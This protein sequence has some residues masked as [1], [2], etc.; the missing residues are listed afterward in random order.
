MVTL[1]EIAKA[2]KDNTLIM[3]QLLKLPFMKGLLAIKAGVQ[4]NKTVL[5]LMTQMRNITTAAMF[6]TANGHIGKGASVADNF[7]ILFDDFVGKNKDP[8]KLKETL[9][10][11]LENG[12]LDSSTIAQELEQLI[13]EL[14]GPSSVGGK[15]IAQGKTSDQIIEQLFTRKGALGKVVNKAIESY[16]LGDNLWKLF[17][18]NYT[19]SQLK[20]ALKNL[21]DVK[22]YFREIEG[23]EFRPLKADGTKKT[24]DDALKEIAGIQ[25]R[26]VYPNYS[27]IP[28]FVQNVR[29]FPVLGNFVAFISEMWRNSFQ[30]ARRGIREMKST[31][32]YLRQIGARRLLGYTTTVGIA[33]PVAMESAQ[34]MTGITEEMYDAYKNRFAPEYEKTS[35]MMPVTKQQ[36]DRSWKASNLS[37]LVPYADV[38]APF[39]AAFQTVQEGRNTDQ[40]TA[41]LYADA[42][43]QF[44]MRGLEPFLAPSI[45]FETSQ[46]LIPNENLQFRTKQGGLIADMKN[47]P[48]WFSKVL[49]HTYK[50][51][52]PT[53][54]RSAEEI[55]QAIGGDLSK[56]GVKR[57]LYDTVVK[58]FTGFSVQKQDPYQAMRFKVGGY[59]G[60][61]QNARQ[62][63]TN[64]IIN[65]G[66]LQKDAELLSRGLDAENFP[67]EYEKLQSNNYR[68]LSEAYKDVVALRTLNFTEKEIKDI[69]SGRRAFSKQDVNNLL[70]G[71]FTP[72]NVP[73][74]KK[75]SAVANAV[76]NINRELGT[77]YKVR[78][79]IN[80]QELLEI[81]RKYKNIPLGLSEEEREEFLRSTP[82]RKMDIKE[83]AIEERM[84]LIEDQQSVKPQTPAGPNLPDPQISNMFAANIN[85]TTGLT[86]TESALLSPTE[87]IIRQRSRT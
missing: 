39:K 34:K 31:N 11:A 54:I 70:S 13:P 59:A 10:E 14:M 81:R 58:V 57:D 32:P 66:K 41:L 18:Y 53:T 84:Q 20:P 62:A 25:I 51:V 50:K 29:K 64:D 52:T 75:D 49:Y 61:M 78:D 77:D 72:E 35:D 69:I 9:E 42:L 40:G 23:Y 45:A 15:T 85:P 22:K 30:I 6:A 47:D 65:A 4:M 38:A 16:Q 56:S 73:N 63:F 48:D 43:R 2:L 27:M 8:Q 79:F 87:Q 33:A 7:R 60:D 44:V 17:G 68:I 67:K 80:R 36:K 82:E 26:D 19:K 12:A 24:L 3:D 28:S 46:E 55:A 21:D 86:Q 5:S 1:P 76:K 83:P 71:F 37:Y 74:F